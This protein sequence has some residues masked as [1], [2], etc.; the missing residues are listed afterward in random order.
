VLVA[1]DDPD[2]VSVTRLSLRS[3]R[4]DDRP[5]RVVAAS[6]G[7]QAREV[8]SQRDD[9]AVV[10]LDVYMETSDAGFR[11]AEWIAQEPRL[12]CVR[13]V[14]RTGLQ[15][16]GSEDITRYQI[17]DYL[18]KTGVTVERLRVV[19]A[20]S[21]RTYRD[22]LVS[23]ARQQALSELVMTTPSFAPPAASVRADPF[24]S[25]VRRWLRGG[26]EPDQ[27]TWDRYI[28]LEVDQDLSRIAL[29]WTI[30]ALKRRG[31][32]EGALPDLSAEA[33]GTVH[34][35][36]LEWAATV[37]S[38]ATGR[39]TAGAGR[40]AVVGARALVSSAG[41][42]PNVV[43][44]PF[45]RF[46]EYQA[47]MRHFAAGI[48]LRE[49]S[50]AVLRL[51]WLMLIHRAWA[52][53]VAMPGA[54]SSDVER[55]AVLLLQS[56]RAHSFSQGVALTMLVEQRVLPLWQIDGAPLPHR[57]RILW[58]QLR[59]L[60][61]WRN[62][63]AHG[64]TGDEDDFARSVEEAGNRLV[65]LL[66][67][68]DR[69]LRIVKAWLGRAQH[70]GLDR[71]W[72]GCPEPIF[73][74][75]RS[76]ATFMLER[77][78]PTGLLVRSLQ[79]NTTQV[80]RPEPD[81]DGILRWSAF[82]ANEDRGEAIGPAD[83]LEAPTALVEAVVGALAAGRSVGLTGA[84]SSGKTSVLDLVGKALDDAGWVALRFL[85]TAAGHVGTLEEVRDSV[86]RQARR[87]PLRVPPALAREH[88][89]PVDPGGCADWFAKIRAANPRARI[90]LLVDALD[91]GSHH[92]EVLRWLEA[93]GVP[94]LV[95]SVRPL[96]STGAPEVQISVDGWYRSPDGKRFLQGYLA[97]RHRSVRAQHDMILEFA[98]GRF[99]WVRHFAVGVART[100][101]LPDQDPAKYYE[102]HLRWL[103]DRAGG[104]PAYLTCLRH[105]LIT[106][107]EADIPLTDS[108]LRELL[109]GEAASSPRWVE[110][111][112]PV[113]AWVADLVDVGSPRDPRWARDV[114]LLGVAQD[115][116]ER[117]RAVAHPPLARWLQSGALPD[118]WQEARVAVRARLASMCAVATVHP[119]TQRER[120]VQLRGYDHVAR[121]PNPNE[122][123]LAQMVD[124]VPH[125]AAL[126]AAE[127]PG[128]WVAVTRARYRATRG[129]GA[130]VSASAAYQ[131]GRTMVAACEQTGAQAVLAEGLAQS[132]RE[133]LQDR[134]HLLAAR[135]AWLRLDPEAAWRHL[136]AISANGSPP[137]AQVSALMRARVLA[138]M[139]RTLGARRA[140]H[141]ASTLACRVVPDVEG[142]SALEHPV[143]AALSAV[144]VAACA[145]VESE[146]GGAPDAIARDAML[147]LSARLD[148]CG[149]RFAA[150]SRALV[151]RYAA[152]SVLAT[153]PGR[154]VSW[155]E[156]EVTRWRSLLLVE[157][158]DRAASRSRSLAWQYGRAHHFLA[159]AHLA[160]GHTVLAERS[161]QVSRSW[162]EV[163]AVATEHPRAMRDLASSNA[164]LALIDATRGSVGADVQMQHAV[165]M[166]RRVYGVSAT[167][168]VEAVADV[169]VRRQ[170]MLADIR[171][172]EVRL[173][174]GLTSG[175]HELLDPLERSVEAME[176]DEIRA[177]IARCHAV[178]A[179]GVVAL[180]CPR[181]WPFVGQGG[182]P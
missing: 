126:S 137:L 28:P 103:E 14:I 33:R 66:G 164:L 67:H 173:L 163:V 25:G 120:Y 177:A 138:A 105:T 147:R 86:A 91:E 110:W 36:Y 115:A 50:E 68:A 174:V 5:V 150:R 118:G 27:D 69:W 62:D 148:G 104:L 176:F 15:Q 64:P 106:M 175:A 85:R 60:V 52:T 116:D 53:V 119:R 48:Y 24:M 121:G 73:W 180:Q 29:G 1:D 149:E 136:Q 124:S 129:A 127:D 160:V 51:I 107:S 154:A 34:L 94:F 54:P 89:L 21:I 56:V 152:L 9:V 92:S 145:F 23:A 122:H 165:A 38:E 171:W 142:P 128:F 77:I 63:V 166:L 144:T 156:E 141:D 72:E 83:E 100:G 170:L 16:L 99:G 112:A 37:V 146:A 79:D 7:A 132:E 108:L 18:D 57:D 159:S 40:P 30:A 133:D 44:D 102:A 168:P 182:P 17:H 3:M 19:V 46:V 95:T 41:A 87:S 130:R 81:F 135:S 179:T 4:V 123:A 55:A 31:W 97:R 43:S 20:G 76:Q 172:A 98:E 26:E 90:A 114:G 88:P 11:V 13:V 45:V 75:D 70:P 22:L 39:P 35:R 42:W 113:L 8:L 2:V 139:G 157:D 158:P 143:A 93:T 59:T 153:D 6:S 125:D 74:M 71:E 117:V 109:V 10:L 169:W 12:A 47:E 167:A 101:V 96:D 32:S 151:L 162:L 78:V 131:Y 134:L 49:T 178:E 61:K 161:A 84:T 58:A 82:A 80:I 155:L 140:A 111:L 181:G 65:V